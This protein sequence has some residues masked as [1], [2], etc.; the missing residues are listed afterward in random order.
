MKQEQ[1]H[2]P[3]GLPISR[4]MKQNDQVTPTSAGIVPTSPTPLSGK[5]AS[6]LIGG[7]GPGQPAAA[8]IAVEAP[9]TATARVPEV[10]GESSFGQNARP[11]R[12]GPIPEYKAPPSRLRDIAT[13]EIA[14]DAASYTDGR[15]GNVGWGSR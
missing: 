8:T 5:P 11:E 14:D 9:T 12:G 6:Y 4:Q 15:S 3:E 1:E 13:R 2:D 7:E 10:G